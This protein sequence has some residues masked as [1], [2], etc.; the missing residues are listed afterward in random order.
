LQWIVFMI[1]ILLNR[2]FDIEHVFSCMMI[3]IITVFILF[4]ADSDDLILSLY[5]FLIL[6]LFITLDED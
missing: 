1:I 6:F 5:E 4:I 2:L 3:N